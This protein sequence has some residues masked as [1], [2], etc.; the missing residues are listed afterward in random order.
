MLVVCSFLFFILGTSAVQDTITP[1]QSI[2]DGETL[3]SAGGTFELG[4]FSPGNST[5]RYLGIWYTGVSNRTVAWVANRETPLTDHS[6]VLNVTQ[7]G[8]L[9]LLDGM[10]IRFWSSNTSRTAKNPVVQLLESGN[11]AVK[12][13]NDDDPENFLWQSFDHPTDNLLP[14][15]KLGRIF[16]TGLD[17]Y[18]SSWK[19]SEDPA[20][21]QFSLWIDPHGFPQLVI[22]N[23]STLHYRAGSWNGLRFTGTPKLSPNPEFLYRFELNNEEVYYEVD[24][25]GRLMSRLFLN[26]SGFIQRLVRTTQSKGWTD[27]YDA[28]EN[29][30][31]IYSFCGAHARC[32]TDSSSVCACLDG[33]EP[34]SPEE[35]IMSN[36][37]KGCVRTRQLN[38]EKGDEF[39]KYIGLKLPDTSNSWFDRSM[40]LQECGEMCSKNCSC[41]AYAT[42]NI[43]AEGSGCLLWFGNLTD[44]IEYDQGGQDFYI[45][46]ATVEKDDKNASVKKQVGIIVGSVIL[47]AMLLVGLIFY[48]LKRKLKKQ[49]MM[50]SNH[51]M[52]YSDGEKEEME[53][54]VFDFNTIAKATDNFSNDNKL[55]EGGF[56]PVYKGTLTEG[57]EIAV[58]RLSKCSGQ[59]LEEFKNEIKLI[60]KL[61]HRN[62]VKLL[63][64]CI[65]ADESMLIY[66]YMPNKSLDYF[67][68]DQIR[69]R[70]LQWP[71]LIHIIG[72]IARGILY[73]H[74]DSRMR[75][76]HRDLKASN[77]LLD[78]DMNPKISDFG[79]ARIFRGDEIGANTNKVVGTYGYM[80]PEY[81]VDGLF[82]VKSDVFSFGALVLEIVSGKKNWRFSHPAHNHNLL[83]H[84]WILWKEDRPMELIDD[85]LGDSCPQFEVLRCIHVG[86]LCVQQRPEDRPNMS[87][88]ILMLGSESSLP[89]PKQPGFFTERN[90]P[91]TDNSSSSNHMYSGT[92]QITILDGR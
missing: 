60:A 58:K 54:W 20:P 51:K 70:F 92:D 56:G 91:E 71:K 7:Q 42:L 27:V 32:K 45:R 12:D 8:I 50:K 16:S 5:R 1:S 14:G 36:W 44:M 78:N 77:V 86:L 76:I 87:S 19:S 33:F 62:L 3:V 38:C 69:R 82:S 43:S 68:F 49:G 46:M 41:G 15:M 22:R 53:L 9:V 52:A 18:L 73:L 39:P 65:Q 83:G 80:S 57:Q 29:R 6:G 40:G 37:S 10:N 75:I 63:G 88:V 89:Q 59:G 2:R 72:G 25:Q 64:C 67:I 74:E 31:D 24:D 61:Q 11:L 17:K 30:C 90:L 81:A 48:I 79:M 85:N 23:G 13:G 34:E 26:Q 66:E 35:W 84:A 21:G 4:F 28:P 55:G 47:A